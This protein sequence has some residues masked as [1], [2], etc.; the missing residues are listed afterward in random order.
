MSADD[1]P[2]CNAAYPN[3]EQDTKTPCHRN[4]PRP[5]AAI[6]HAPECNQAVWAI[7]ARFLDAAN[8]AMAR[9]GVATD[10]IQPRH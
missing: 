6:G 9:L 5:V 1:E 2:D 7:V 3:R 4:Y 10:G 8:A